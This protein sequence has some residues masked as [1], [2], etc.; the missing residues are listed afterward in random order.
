M[1]IIHDSGIF[2]DRFSEDESFE[3]ALPLHRYI[4]SWKPAFSYRLTHCQSPGSE[5]KSHSEVRV[6]VTA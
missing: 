5:V 1:L 4:Y 2:S 3:G 6:T